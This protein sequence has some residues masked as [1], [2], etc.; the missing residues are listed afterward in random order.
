MIINLKETT[1]KNTE[2]DWLKTNV[3]RF[4]RMVQGQSDLLAVSKLVLSRT[5]AAGERAAGHLLYQ[6]C[7]RRA[8]SRC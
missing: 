4:T 2:Q 8:R 3:A 7:S 5:G 1:R 6:R